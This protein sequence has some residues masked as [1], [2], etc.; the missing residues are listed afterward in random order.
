MARRKCAL[1]LVLAM[2]VGLTIVHPAFGSSAGGPVEAASASQ[3]KK[4]NPRR[5]HPRGGRCR[6]PIAVKASTR[7][8]AVELSP[9]QVLSVKGSPAGRLAVAVPDH[10]PRPRLGSPLIVPVSKVAPRGVL[11]VVTS[12]SRRR[13]RIVAFTRPA[14]LDEA[15][16]RLRI[17]VGDVSLGDLSRAGVATS[18]G[19][20]LFTCSGSGP[21]PRFDVRAD[22]SKLQPQF[23]LDI[24]RPELFFML[25]GQ[26]DIGVDVAS[27]AKASCKYSGNAK[28]VI[29]I[30]GTP[31]VIT[32]E[33]AIDGSISGRVG[34]GFGWTP[35][36]AVGAQVGP[37]VNRSI[38]SFNRGRFTGP[39]FSGSGSASLFLGADVGISVAERV[40]VEGQAGPR[41]QAKVEASPDSSCLDGQ[42]SLH[43]ALKAYA[44]VFVRHWS[45]EIAKGE[46]GALQ[47]FHSC[48]SER[49]G[50]PGAPAGPPPAP[51]PPPTYQFVG[52]GDR[53]GLTR[54]TGCGENYFGIL[55]G[56]SADAQEL[57][58]LCQQA[59]VYSIAGNGFSQ[60]SPLPPPGGRGCCY[61]PA[62][63]SGNGRFALI[64]GNEIVEAP[65][66]PYILTE[67]SVYLYDRDGGSPERVDVPAPGGHGECREHAFRSPEL[68]LSDNGS[69]AGFMTCARLSPG[70]Q[71]SLVEGYVRDRAAGTTTRLPT[72]CGGDYTPVSI[73]ADGRYVGY[74]GCTISPS[75]KCNGPH[76]FLYDRVASQRL[77]ASPECGEL[78]DISSDGRYVLSSGPSF[79]YDT[80][81]LTVFDRV[82][83]VAEMVDTTPGLVLSGTISDDGRYIAYF[84]QPAY[85]AGGYRLDRVALRKA[86]LDISDA[87]VPS[88]CTGFF[89]SH[90]SRDGRT[91]A[92]ESCK[93]LTDE[94]GDSMPAAYVARYP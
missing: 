5:Q 88:G 89:R 92:F 65:E 76:A 78:L 44:D 83:G 59:G 22:F 15:Y 72:E 94:N 10:G 42:A 58:G 49:S 75:T 30:A 26:V 73:S 57:L 7:P 41:L 55:S 56:L 68:G 70:D 16:S 40:G 31:V 20:K 48:R 54:L 82:T 63:L 52:V 17:R 33:P 53:T 87:G 45:F 64:S 19:A 34:A 67:A 28:F 21:T 80:E 14:A 25:S 81:G 27:T 39:D 23:E 36:L 9:R 74:T 69:V 29:P 93:S 91:V 35:R 86:R 8:A 13:G 6:S 12:I 24:A 84:N 11:G 62:A 85:G 1:A 79:V 66:D 71:N 51:P 2:G 37:D 18:S 77:D 90:I 32:V 46:F 60:L 3:C 43:A 47:L 38:H 50:D 4:R 61:S